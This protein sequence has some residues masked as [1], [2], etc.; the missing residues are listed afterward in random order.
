MDLILFRYFYFFVMIL[1]NNI[2]FYYLQSDKFN[3]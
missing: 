3:I 1:K 2:N